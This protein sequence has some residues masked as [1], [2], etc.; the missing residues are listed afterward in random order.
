MTRINN[1]LIT[2]V[3]LFKKKVI[4][5]DD[6]LYN[7]YNEDWIDRSTINVSNKMILIDPVKL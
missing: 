2:I 6:I 5:I 4:I 1:S 3:C 7:S